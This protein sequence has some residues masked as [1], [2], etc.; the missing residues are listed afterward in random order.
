VN[1]H[2]KTESSSANNGERET[3]TREK[4]FEFFNFPTNVKFHYEASADE[5]QSARQALTTPRGRSS[6][7]AVAA[8]QS[9]RFMIIINNEK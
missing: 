2:N 9:D 1:L 6:A 3:T 8:E 7:A 5:L 4:F